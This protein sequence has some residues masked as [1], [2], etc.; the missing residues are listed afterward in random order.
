MTPTATGIADAERKRGPG[1]PR[2]NR[3]VDKEA[4]KLVAQ[5]TVPEPPA[6]VIKWD[7]MEAWMRLLTPEMWGSL[8][9]YLYRIRPRIIRQLRDPDSPK[10]IDLL[11]GPFDMD[12]LIQRHGGGRYI[13]EATDSSKPRKTATGE[14]QSSHLFRCTFDIDEVRHEPKVLYEELD[15]NHRD[16]MSYIQM[17]QHRGILDSK[18]KVVQNNNQQAAQNMNGVPAEWLKEIFGFVRSMSAEQQAQLKVKLAPEESLSKSVGDILLEKMKQDDPSKQF[19]WVKDLLA[20]LKEIVGTSKPPDTSNIYGPFISMLSE[21]NKTLV[22]LLEKIGNQKERE[23]DK[24][25]DLDRLAKVIDIAD[26]LRGPSSGGRRGPWEIGLDYARE[27][28]PPI[29][30]TLGAW[31]ALRQ[32]AA[33]AATAAGVGAAPAPPVAFDPY[34]RPDLMRQASQAA[35]QQPPNV[36]PGPPPPPPP[37]GTPPPTTNTPNTQLT[38]LLGQYGNLVINA[39]NNGTAGYEFADYL[40]GLLGNATHAMIASQGEDAIVSTML[41]VPQIGIFGETRIREFTHQF[42]HYE[43]FQDDGEAEAEAQ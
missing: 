17:L 20:S 16:N 21:Q 15:V 8:M 3:D 19:S 33:P 11:T 31:M 36:P 34:R 42:I 32:G 2:L 22:T 9:L 23:I 37:P 1:R 12:Y 30:Q 4:E 10:Y 43:E 24:G 14:P 5:S 39:L 28:G 29:L 27:L 40:T 7:Q 41:T 18:G 13:I 35:T 25:D 38:A 26:K 6:K